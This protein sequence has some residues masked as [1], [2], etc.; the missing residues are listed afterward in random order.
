MSQQIA[1]PP[2]TP[3]GPPP[4]ALLV[5]FERILSGEARYDDDQYHDYVIGAIRAVL[6][7]RDLRQAYALDQQ[8][9]KGTQK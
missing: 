6:L 2:P 8:Q 4:L 3:P 5:E 9:R 7:A 1:P